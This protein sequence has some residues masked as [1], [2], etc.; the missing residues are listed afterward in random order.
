LTY[1]LGHMTA[2]TLQTSTESDL[3]STMPAATIDGEAVRSNGTHEATEPVPSV[4]NDAGQLDS[5]PS[6]PLGVKPKG[7]LYLFEGVNARHNTGIWAS[8]PEEMLM[9]ILEYVD[10]SSLFQLGH[11][12]KYFYA[13]CHSEELWKALFL[14]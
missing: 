9:V 5:I 13:F 2:V 10:K 3:E 7:N 1:N 6:H 8:F 12:C 4:P 14:Q 11:T